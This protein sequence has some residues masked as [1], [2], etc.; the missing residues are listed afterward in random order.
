MPGH[1]K[2]EQSMMKAGDKVTVTIGGVQKE[3][4][5]LSEDELKKSRKMTMEEYDRAEEESH[6]LI[7][8]A[9]KHD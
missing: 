7:Q 8:E 5:I 4:T 1:K 6:R 9:Q 2:K 3:V